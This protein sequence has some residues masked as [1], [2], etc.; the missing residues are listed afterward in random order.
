MAMLEQGARIPD[1]TVF[2]EDT[3]A[4][5]MAELTA[6]GTVLLAFY[7]YD[8]TDTCRNQLRGLRDRQEQFDAAGVRLFGVSRDSP[9]SH[10]KYSQ[11][12][13]LKFPLLSDWS[14]D[15]VRAFGVA[16]SLDGLE[17]TPIRSCFLVT[18]GVIVGTWRYGDDEM[19][20][21]EELLTAA[22]GHLSTT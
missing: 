6:E 8:W 9:Y 17:D 12:Q 7:L 4:V 14:G 1:V 5:S 10:I 11:Q 15:A 21:A 16:Q 2:D 18:D 19:P 13:W 3:V 20:D 22:R